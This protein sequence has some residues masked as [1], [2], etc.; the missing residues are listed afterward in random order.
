MTSVK[1]PVT[2]R[3]PVYLIPLLNSLITDH[4]DL[5]NTGSYT[6]QWYV[7]NVSNNPYEPGSDENGVTTALM[8]TNKADD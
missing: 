6:D 5:A 8:E 7:D 4:Q 3:C 1:Q 2:C